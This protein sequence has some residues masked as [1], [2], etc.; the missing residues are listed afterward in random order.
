[1]RLTEPISRKFI[2]E[3]FIEF[4]DID[5]ILFNLDSS[6]SAWAEACKKIMDGEVSVVKM[7]DILKGRSR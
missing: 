4:D 2:R 5:N 7:N 1:M 3:N 6:S